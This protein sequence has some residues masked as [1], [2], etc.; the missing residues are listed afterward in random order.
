MFFILSNSLA[1][2]LLSECTR[3]LYWEILRTPEDGCPYV[4]WS[5]CNRISIVPWGGRGRK[6]KSCHSDQNRRFNRTS[7]FSL[8]YGLFRAFLWLHH[9]E[10]VRYFFAQNRL[11]I[12]CDH[13]FDHIC[14]EKAIFH[15][16]FWHF[17]IF[18]LC[19]MTAV[20]CSWEPP[21]KFFGSFFFVLLRIS[22]M[23]KVW[24]LAEFLGLSIIAPQLHLWTTF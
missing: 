11:K 21:F 16:G 20:L 6:F 5:N 2:T 13:M 1:G 9:L 7:D 4:C 10:N 14:H 23:T 18:I 15:K 22:F 12:G 8:F 3:R 19:K 17:A 24:P